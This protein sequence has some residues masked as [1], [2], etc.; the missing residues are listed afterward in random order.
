MNTDTLIN[1]A[2]RHAV[3]DKTGGSARFCL[4]EAVEQHAAG[5]YSGARRWAMKSLAHSVGVLHA[6]YQKAERGVAA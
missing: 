3:E 1:L 4:A 5:N 6:D 2:R